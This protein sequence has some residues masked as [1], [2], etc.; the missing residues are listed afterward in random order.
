VRREYAKS[1]KET[2]T[3][4]IKRRKSDRRRDKETLRH[5]NIEWLEVYLN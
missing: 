5:R 2:I 1:S 4:R 3:K